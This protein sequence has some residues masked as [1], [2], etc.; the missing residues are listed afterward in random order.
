VDALRESP[1]DGWS[2]F[3]EDETDIHWL[4]L[5]ANSWTKRGVQVY[6]PT[7]RDNQK[8]YCFGAV[9]FHTC[10]SCFRLSRKKD[11]KAFVA[12][13]AAADEPD[14]QE[15]H[16]DL[17]QLLGP[18]DPSGPRLCQRACRQ[19]AV[20]VS[21]NLQPVAKPDRTVLAP[22]QKEGAR[23]Q[24]LRDYRRADASYGNV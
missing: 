8:R 6:V 10:E 15:D 3:F 11:S 7:P 1:P 2:V 16:L 18:Q 19:A 14:V 17:R 23:K 9:D 22:P 5:L 21:A 13:G 4:P 20:G 12:F 24:I